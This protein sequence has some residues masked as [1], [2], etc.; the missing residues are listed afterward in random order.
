MNKT[1]FYVHDEYFKVPVRLEGM[2]YKT[3]FEDEILG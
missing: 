2:K 3:L 1:L